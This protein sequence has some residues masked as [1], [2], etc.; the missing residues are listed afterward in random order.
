MLR[1]VGRCTKVWRTVQ[2]VDESL[3]DDLREQLEV[4]DPREHARIEKRLL[5]RRDRCRHRAGLQEKDLTA[6]TQRRGDAQRKAL[7]GFLSEPLR[8]RVSAVSFSVF[9]ITCPTSA[10]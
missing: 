8:L 9:C 10:S 6:E 2:P 5:L 3:D 1:E 7:D 4:P